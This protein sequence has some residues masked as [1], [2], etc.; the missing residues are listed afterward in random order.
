MTDRLTA[1]DVEKQEFKRKVR[2]F[3]PEEVRYY[4]KSV[5]DEIERLNLENGQLRED[6][7]RLKKERDEIQNREVVLQ[8]TLVTAQKMSDDLKERAQGQ[9]ELLVRDARMKAERLLQ[10]AQDSSPAS[11]RR[12]AAAR[13]K[14]TCSRSGCAAPSRST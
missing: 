10:D 5:A 12:S 13:S 8:K 7:G 11:R 4:L 14:R 2:G 3:D 6:A 1:M 9:A